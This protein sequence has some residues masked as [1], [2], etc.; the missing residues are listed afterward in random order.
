MDCQILI[1]N[2]KGIVIE[3]PYCIVL[4]FLLILEIYYTVKHN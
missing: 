3:D 2:P 1:V 4:L